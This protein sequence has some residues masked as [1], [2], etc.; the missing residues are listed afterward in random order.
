[1]TTPIMTLPEWTAA[2]ASPW[3]T[4]MT[5]M[6]RLEAFGQSVIV[7]VN[8]TLTAP[9]GSPTAG[10]CHFIGA[11]PTGAW[12]GQGGKLTVYTGSSWEFQTPREGWLLYSLSNDTTYQV[13]GSGGLN[14]LAFESLDELTTLDVITT[15][16]TTYIPLASNGNKQYVTQTS[17]SINTI[18]LPSNSAQAFPI[19]TALTFEQVGAGVSTFAAGSG[20]TVRSRSGA[21]EFAGQYAVA[22]AVKVATDTWTVTGDLIV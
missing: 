13:N 3:I 18:E 14:A 2:Q 17:G 9:P 16:D 4:V 10:D 11:A 15:S 12:S 5:A 8:T 1:M 19:G 20:A 6:R 7:C 21:L 22:T